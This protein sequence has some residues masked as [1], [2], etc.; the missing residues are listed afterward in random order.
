MLKSKNA[1]ANV[2]EICS[3]FSSEDFTVS[4]LFKSLNN[5]ELFFVYGVR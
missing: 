2:K 1:S 3:M 4:G 5:F